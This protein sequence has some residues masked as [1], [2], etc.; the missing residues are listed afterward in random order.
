VGEGTESPGQTDRERVVLPFGLR[1]GGIKKEGLTP[2]FA[3]YSL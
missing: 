1:E 3:D 2:L